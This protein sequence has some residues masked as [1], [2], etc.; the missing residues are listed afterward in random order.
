MQ[1]A[2]TYRRLT[3]VPVPAL[4]IL[5]LYVIRKDMWVELSKDGSIDVSR[6]LQTGHSE[7]FIDNN[8]YGSH[9]PKAASQFELCVQL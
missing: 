3:P 5:F 8:L 9:S 7:R 4:R 1:K 6:H 2:P